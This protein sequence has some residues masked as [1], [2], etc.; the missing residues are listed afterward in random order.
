MDRHATVGLGVFSARIPTATWTARTIHLSIG[1]EADSHQSPRVVDLM[2]PNGERLIGDQV[3][4]SE[5]GSRFVETR[6]DVDRTAPS[7]S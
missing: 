1:I 6:L 5:D 4:T 3:Q 2:G 7:R